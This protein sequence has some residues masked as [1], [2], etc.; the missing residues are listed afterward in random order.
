MTDERE[1][2]ARKVY[3]AI[4]EQPGLTIAFLAKKLDM[5]KGQVM[6]ALIYMGDLD[7]L[8]SEDGWGGIHPFKNTEAPY[9]GH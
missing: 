5:G 2:V 3:A 4:C 6:N 9:G 1:A 8:V 7:L